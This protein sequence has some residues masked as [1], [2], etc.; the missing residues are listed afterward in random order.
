MKAEE[1][2]RKSGLILSFIEVKLIL[3]Q[4]VNCNYEFRLLIFVSVISVATDGSLLEST[5]KSVRPQ[6]DAEQYYMF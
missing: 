6:R 1:T 3:L 4:F 5:D 2:E